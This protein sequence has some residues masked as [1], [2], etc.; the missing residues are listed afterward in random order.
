MG[1]R[2]RRIW[3]L[4]LAGAGLFLWAW[5]EHR[6]AKLH[7]HGLGPVRWTLLA[8]S[9]FLSLPA[10]PSPSF[11]GT[12]RLYAAS[13]WLQWPTWVVPVMAAGAVVGLLYRVVTELIDGAA[14]ALAAVLLVGLSWYRMLS[15]LVF[16]Q[17]PL[18]LMA[19]LLVWSWLR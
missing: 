10:S 15:V 4:V 2:T 17:V 1:L 3:T 18:L 9:A 5:V 7:G 6:A 16:A 14:G 12:A 11:P 13:G 19:L 8:L